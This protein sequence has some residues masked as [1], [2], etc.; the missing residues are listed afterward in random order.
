MS[1]I[2]LNSKQYSVAWDS[3][4]SPRLKSQSVDTGLTGKTLIQNF[5]FTD[6]WWKMDLLVWETETR[7]G[8]GDLDDLRTAYALSTCGYTDIDG[9]SHTVVMEG[10]FPSKNL[11]PVQVYKIP[12]FLR[13][14]QS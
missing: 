6:Y 10:D 8:Y 14:Y 13:K 12:I 2:T 4:D 7:S 11:E 3:Y 9:N 5:A 1:T